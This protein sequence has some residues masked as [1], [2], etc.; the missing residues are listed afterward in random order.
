MEENQEGPGC[1]TITIDYSVCILM[2]MVSN[3]LCFI[4]YT[5]T[6]KYSYLLDLL[7]YELGLKPN[8]LKV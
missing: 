2:F 4:E 7:V 5:H 6:A 3:Q 1:L 8:L